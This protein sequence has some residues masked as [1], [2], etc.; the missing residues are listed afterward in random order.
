MQQRVTLY[1]NLNIF[2]EDPL[3]GSSDEAPAAAARLKTSILMRWEATIAGS[4]TFVGFFLNH[5]CK[6][7]LTFMGGERREKKN[8]LPH[9]D[10]SARRGLNG[11]RPALPGRVHATPV[12]PK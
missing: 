10:F 11:R 5:K 3:K 9:S 7:S 4:F 2:F 12:L 1:L 8:L 6:R